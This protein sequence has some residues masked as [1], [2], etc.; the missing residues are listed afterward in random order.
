M[1]DV[2]HFYIH[3]SASTIQRCVSKR[4]PRASHQRNI[5]FLLRFT[6]TCTSRFLVKFFSVSRF[7]VGRT[8]GG[9]GTPRRRRGD[10]CAAACGSVQKASKQAVANPA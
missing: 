6:S 9:A 3:P 5:L 8:T 1:S 7:L 2:A 4:E 10:G